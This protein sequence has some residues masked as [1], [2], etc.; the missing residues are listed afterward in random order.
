MEFLH[1]ENMADDSLDG[2]ILEFVEPLIEIILTARLPLEKGNEWLHFAPNV[3]DRDD[4]VAHRRHDPLGR[5]G[6]ERVG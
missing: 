2:V 3:L 5:K 1:E 4:L 6:A